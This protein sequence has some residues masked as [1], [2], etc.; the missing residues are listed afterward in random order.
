MELK[1]YKMLAQIRGSMLST[2]EREARNKVEY[3]KDKPEESQKWMGHIANP[4]KWDFCGLLRKEDKKLL[5]M[6]EY[7]LDDGMTDIQER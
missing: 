4:E 5:E 1:A 3:C 7:L 6:L 2:I